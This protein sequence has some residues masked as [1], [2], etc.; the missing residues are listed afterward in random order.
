MTAIPE[1]AF[2]AAPALGRHSSTFVTHQES[3]EAQGRQPGLAEISLEGQKL[4]LR[5]GPE[6]DWKAEKATGRA[7]ESPE[8]TPDLC[9]RRT[10]RSRVDAS[11]PPPLQGR[12]QLGAQASWVPPAV[13]STSCVTPPPPVGSGA[14][15]RVPSLP[16]CHPAPGPAPA[17][18]QLR[19][20]IP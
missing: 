20:T 2:W 7:R 18:P 16:L 6:A 14:A 5:R 13:P 12:A 4:S 8:H 10:W 11:P 1:R 15:R 17:F 19:V 3:S 9:F